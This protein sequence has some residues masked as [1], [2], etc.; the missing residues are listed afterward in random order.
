MQEWGNALP[1]KI[2]LL[3]L[4]E[5]HSEDYPDIR[6]KDTHYKNNVNYSLGL[7]KMFSKIR[8]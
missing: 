3:N 2:F 1:Q 8:Y 7:Q 5:F 4:G 6:G